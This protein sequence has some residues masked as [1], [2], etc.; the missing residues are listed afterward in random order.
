MSGP[1]RASSHFIV[2][3]D[4][5]ISCIAVGF[6]VG[7]APSKKTVPFLKNQF[8]YNTTRKSTTSIGA[9]F[10]SGPRSGLSLF[11]L[12]VF[13]L[14][15]QRHLP[16]LGFSGPVLPIDTGKKSITVACQFQDLPDSSILLLLL[17]RQR[18][19]D[20]PYEIS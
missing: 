13:S 2:S 18:P 12:F 10:L 4:A 14:L 16:A 7:R 17:S 19:S 3:H 8:L 9:T 15:L 20:F 5:G 6:P 1:G 11:R